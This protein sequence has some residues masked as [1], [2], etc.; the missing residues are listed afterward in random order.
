[1]K[2]LGKIFE[3]NIKKS[4]PNDVFYLR[5]KDS[6]G[7][8]G[9]YNN[10]VRFTQNNPCDAILFNGE[11]MILLEMKSHKGKSLPLSCIRENQ[12][13]ELSIYQYYKNVYGCVM[14]NFSDCEETYLIQISQITEFIRKGERKSIPISWCKENGIKI[15]Q[16]KLRTNY[17]YNL[18]KMWEEL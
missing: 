3:D 5:L 9:E 15:E 10:T 7:T 18:K 1:M 4:V 13:K 17:R 6:T 16:K 8:W 11:K 2:N 12:L 14:I